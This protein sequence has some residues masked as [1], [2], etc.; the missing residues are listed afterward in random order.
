MGIAI[1]SSVQVGM[2]RSLLEEGLREFEN[3]PEVSVEIGR[4]SIMLTGNR[5]SKLCRP[6]QTGLLCWGS[7][8]EELWLI[9]TCRASDG[10]MVSTLLFASVDLWWV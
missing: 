8:S 2:V 3:A 7:Q 10:V 1:A 4:G 9:A 6:I 5:F